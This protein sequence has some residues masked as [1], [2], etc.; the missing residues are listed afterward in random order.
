[1]DNNLMDLIHQEYKDKLFI[2]ADPET[3]EIFMHYNKN[4]S[5]VDVS[6]KKKGLIKELLNESDLTEKEFADKINIFLKLLTTKIKSGFLS[7]MILFGLVREYLFQIA[8][9]G[10]EEDKQKQNEEINNKINKA[11]EKNKE[12][13]KEGNREED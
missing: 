6:T 5:L 12:R 13:N 3:D 9:V 8:K 1:M 7:S 2:V 10:N 11:L 4:Y